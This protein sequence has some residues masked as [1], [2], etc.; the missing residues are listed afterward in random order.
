MHTN[1]VP[2]Q[3]FPGPRLYVASAS[4]VLIL[5]FKE[6]TLAELEGVRSGWSFALRVSCGW[7][8]EWASEMRASKWSAVQ[9]QSTSQIN[10]NSKKPEGLE[11]F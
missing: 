7:D 6:P 3:L 1:R 10:E 9:E 4:L 2:R 5:T 8:L 11:Q